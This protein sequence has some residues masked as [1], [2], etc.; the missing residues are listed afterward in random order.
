M[1]GLWE[2]RNESDFRKEILSKENLLR[3]SLF[4]KSTTKLDSSFLIILIFIIDEQI[5]VVRNIFKKDGFEYT[6]T[7]INIYT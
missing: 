4:K 6:M 2:G 3:A 1:G 5:D 7:S